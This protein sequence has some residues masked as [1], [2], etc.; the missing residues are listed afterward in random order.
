[1]DS[2]HVQTM[3][4]STSILSRPPRLGRLGPAT[5]LVDDFRQA[6]NEYG[7][8]ERDMESEKIKEKNW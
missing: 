7:I 5:Y 2:V 3:S 8:R 4:Q 1:M 6:R